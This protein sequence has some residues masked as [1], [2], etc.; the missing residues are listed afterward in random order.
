[1]VAAIETI[2]KKRLV[3]TQIS[4]LGKIDDSLVEDNSISRSKQK[5]FKEFWRQLLGSPADFGFF[6]NPEI[7]TIFIVGSLVST[8][9]QDVEGTKLGAMSVGPYGILRGLGIEPEHASSHIKILGKGGF[10]LI[11]RGYDQDLLKL[12]EALIPINKY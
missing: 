11:I 10:I 6:F 1:M 7:G 8:F 2:K 9:L 4:V 3:N 12:E 5:E